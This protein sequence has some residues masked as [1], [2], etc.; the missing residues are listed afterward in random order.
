MI[1]YP[2]DQLS[3]DLSKRQGNCPKDDQL[4]KRRGNYPTDDQLSER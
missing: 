2:E 4:S 3:K 1:N